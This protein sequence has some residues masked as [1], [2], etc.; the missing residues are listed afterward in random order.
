MVGHL[1]G[2]GAKE[3]TRPLLERMP[4]AQTGRN[5][6]VF[7]NLT[8]SNLPL[9]PSTN[10]TLLEAPD[11]GDWNTSHE[12]DLPCLRAEQAGGGQGMDLRTKQAQDQHSPPFCY[13]A[14]FL[15]TL[16][17]YTCDT[18]AYCE[19]TNHTMTVT[20]SPSK[21]NTKFYKLLFTSQV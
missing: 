11:T 1:G 12:A 10:Q 20:L 9:I 14:S 5:T 3:G 21:R 8:P 7:T 2:A 17:W 4:G 15:L 18:S 19:S 13:S 16:L 6:L